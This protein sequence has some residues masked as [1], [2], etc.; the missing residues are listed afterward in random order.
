VPR[1]SNPTALERTVWSLRHARRLAGLHR[2]LPVPVRGMLLTPLS[3]QRHF[4]PTAHRPLVW[5]M[6][7]SSHAI[8]TPRGVPSALLTIIWRASHVPRDG[9]YEIVA[10]AVLRP[11]VPAI[12][13]SSVGTGYIRFIRTFLC[14]ATMR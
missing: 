2:V 14:A 4:T 3:V 7:I 12:A 13:G 8:V 9:R 5:A 10:G 11:P 1:R 6:A